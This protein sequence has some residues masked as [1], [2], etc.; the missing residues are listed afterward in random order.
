MVQKKGGVSA[1]A[2]YDNL[3]TTLYAICSGDKNDKT[4]FIVSGQ[5]SQAVPLKRILML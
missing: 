1:Y 5:A 4:E 2:L 3:S